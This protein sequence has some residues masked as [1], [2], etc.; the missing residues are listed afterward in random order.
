[1][2]SGRWT[3]ETRYIGE[4]QGYNGLSIADAVVNCTVGG[5]GTPAMR[6]A[7]F[8]TPEELAAINAGAPIVV[9][10]LGRQHPPISVFTGRVPNGPSTDRSKSHE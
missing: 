2:Q 1:M 6:T 4:S 3:D 9:E 10:L 8:P 7:W 5:P